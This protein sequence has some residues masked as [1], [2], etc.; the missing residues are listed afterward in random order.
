MRTIVSIM[1]LMAYNFGYSQVYTEKQTRHR[2]AQLN[3]G[4][5]VQ[6]SFGGSTKYL[7]ALGN[8]QS[9]N[10]TNSFSPRFLIGGTHFWG[11]ADFYI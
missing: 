9:F 2:F 7:D 3:L 6:S 4:L 11:H 1:V 8:I 10:L 5:D